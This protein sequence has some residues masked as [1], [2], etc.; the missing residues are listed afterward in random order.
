VLSVVNSGPLVSADDIDRLFQ[1]FQRL[2]SERNSHD[3][4][5][6][7][8]SIVEAIAWAPRRQGHGPAAARRAGSK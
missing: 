4:L 6:L 3:G 1:P 7:G 5:G 2:A 8:L